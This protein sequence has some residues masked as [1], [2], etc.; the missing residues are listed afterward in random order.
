MTG[1]YQGRFSNL[2][3]SLNPLEVLKIRLGFLGTH[4]LKSL[5]RNQSVDGLGVQSN[6]LKHLHIGPSLAEY[7]GRMNA[8]PT[9]PTIPTNPHIRL[10]ETWSV[11]DVPMPVTSIEGYSGYFSFV[12]KSTN[13]RYAIGYTSIAELPTACHQLLKKFG[14]RANSKCHQIKILILDGSTTNL[15]LNLNEFCETVNGPNG[16]IVK[17][18]VSAPYKHAQN[19]IESHI[20]HEKNAMRTN[21]AYNKAPDLM[22]FKALRYSHK[23]INITN[24]P[25]SR[26]SRQ[27]A[28]TNCRPDVSHFV[29]FYAKG[30]AHVTKSERINTLSD[31]AIQVYMIGYGDD[32]DDNTFLPNIQYKQSYQCYIPPNQIL[33]RHDVIFEHLAPHPSLLNDEVKDRFVETFSSPTTQPTQNLDDQRVQQ[34]ISY[35]TITQHNNTQPTYQDNDDDNTE[36]NFQ[37]GNNNRIRTRNDFE[38]QY[39]YTHLQ[40]NNILKSVIFHDNETPQPQPQNTHL[41]IRNQLIQPPKCQLKQWI[42]SKINP[43][44]SVNYLSNYINQS[45]SYMVPNNNG[46][47]TL[48]QYNTPPKPTSYNESSESLRNIF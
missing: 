21:L 34:I 45:D 38:P 1:G 40:N 31:R 16:P 18:H 23:N 47:I 13:F 46:S 24:A 32:L 37:D 9:Y 29:P 8:F 33:I 3:H 6:E 22:W 36:S 20:Q 39:W 30:Y 15:G 11:D 10:C 17:R 4:T 44:A 25:N 48:Q 41:G 35:P 42:K 27:E 19:L 12:E 5:V 2:L 7:K 14:P 26:I 28:M 43:S